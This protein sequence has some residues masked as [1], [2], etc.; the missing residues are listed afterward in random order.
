ME[1]STQPIEETTKPI[2]VQT[3]KDCDHEFIEEGLAKGNSN[4]NL[5]SYVCKKCGLGYLVDKETQS[6]DE[7]A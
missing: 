7:L 5:T 4:P 3:S 1:E 2:I 6:I